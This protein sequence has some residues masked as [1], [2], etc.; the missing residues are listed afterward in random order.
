LPGAA[1][2]ALALFDD[3]PQD[4]LDKV[5]RWKEWIWPA[6]RAGFEEFRDEPLPCSMQ[7][8][9][10]GKHRLTPLR[11]VGD[12][13]DQSITGHNCLA[14]LI[15]DFATGSTTLLGV[16]EG[17]RLIGHVSYKP[18]NATSANLNS[19][20]IIALRLRNRPFEN[21][22][23]AELTAHFAGLPDTACRQADPMFIEP[24]LAIWRTSAMH[25]LQPVVERL[26]AKAMARFDLSEDTAHLPKCLDHFLKHNDL[27]SAVVLAHRCGHQRAVAP[28]RTNSFMEAQ[29][30]PIRNNDD[31]A[32][33]LQAVPVT[34]AD[35]PTELIQPLAQLLPQPYRAETLGR[36]VLPSLSL[37][38]SICES[39][40][41]SPNLTKFQVNEL[42]KTMT[43]E[44]KHFVATPA[45]DAPPLE[46]LLMLTHILLRSSLLYSLLV[47]PL[48]AREATQLYRNICAAM[49]RRNPRTPQSS[50][51]TRAI[52][53]SALHYPLCSFVLS[54]VLDPVHP[55]ASRTR[56]ASSGTMAEWPERVPLAPQ[57]C[58]FSS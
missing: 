40:F 37:D 36:C 43:D 44:R 39:V 41:T 20:E 15:P 29:Q 47:R 28:P 25:A 12:V 45:H 32:R 11:T 3:H 16:Y 22:W 35:F 49:L 21:A 58:T 56:W 38:L 6:L 14:E 55:L 9:K 4:V 26:Q 27:H 17:G 51:D 52:S 7:P 18:P 57:T 53:E 33:L 1:W 46:R 13:L 48:S 50:I 42:I 8:F 31:L 24:V 34:P 10:L 54:Q 2:A 30:C 5:V 23:L 19:P